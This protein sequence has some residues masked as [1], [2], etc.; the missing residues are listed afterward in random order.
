MP[1]AQVP[2]AA[3]PQVPYGAPSAPG[4]QAPAQPD[5]VPETDPRAISEFRPTLDP[6]GTWVNDE[7]TAR[8]GFPTRT[9]WAVI[10]R[11]T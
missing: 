1:A 6:Y 7:S 11:L 2:P 8:S 9:W 4:P 10:L 5:N 3:G